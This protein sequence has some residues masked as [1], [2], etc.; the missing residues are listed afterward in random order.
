[1]RY[2]KIIFLSFFLFAIAVS[3]SAVTPINAEDYGLPATNVRIENL[4]SEIV[5]W[6]LLIAGPACMVALVYGGIRYAFA[7]SNEDRV[8]Q[9]KKIVRYAI[10][11]VII[12]ISAY[13]ITQLIKS[14]VEGNFPEAPVL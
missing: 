12:I 10:I 6:V 3:A 7:G 1:M 2:L 14:L 8:D 4:I 11:G 9:A 13:A 5:K